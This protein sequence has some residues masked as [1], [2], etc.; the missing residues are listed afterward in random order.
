M[1]CDGLATGRSLRL[2]QHGGGSWRSWLAMARYAPVVLDRKPMT[3]KSSRRSD[4]FL[5]GLADATRVVF[6]S[7]VH[8]DPDSLGSM[9]GLAHLV[10]TKAG[11]PTLLTQDGPISRA[12]NRAMVDVLHLNLMPVEDMDWQ[13]GDAVVMV[14]SQPKTG[15]HTIDG[16]IAIAA[17]LDH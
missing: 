12:E 4:R 1:T 8:P 6:V 7:H 17:V 2:P 16:D 13:P 10:E 3:A 9:L 5:T 14:D 15:R 11:T